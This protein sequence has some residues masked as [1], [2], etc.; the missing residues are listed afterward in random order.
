M[1][2]GASQV[3]AAL[4]S[5]SLTVSACA[6]SSDA[7]PQTGGL[8]WQRCEEGEDQVDVELEC[9]TLDVPNDH[10]L[11]DGLTQRLAVARARAS[12][13]GAR[14]GALLFNLGGPGAESTR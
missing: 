13:P 7:P 1:G 4:L 8:A 5:I 2:V 12:G 6:G 14:L 9:A 11:S 10:R 3:T